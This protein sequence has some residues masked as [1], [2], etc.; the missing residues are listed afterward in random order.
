MLGKRCRIAIVDQSNPFSEPIRKNLAQRGMIE[1][2]VIGIQNDACR[3]IDTA[4]N[5][6]ANA[7]YR[8]FALLERGYK[9][10]ARGEH[11]FKILILRKRQ[12]AFFQQNAFVRY[13]S[14]CNIRAADIKS[15][16]S[17]YNP[18]CFLIIL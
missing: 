17:H 1:A 11:L 16:F 5:G 4:R 12:R 7:L 6:N 9:L 3:A 15:D 18:P 13:Q 8:L 10:L 14:G 2:E